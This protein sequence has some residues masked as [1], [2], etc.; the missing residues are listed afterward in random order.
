MVG[1]L[2]VQKVSQTVAKREVMLDSMKV[3][4]LVVM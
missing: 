4:W 2:V 3:V 1:C